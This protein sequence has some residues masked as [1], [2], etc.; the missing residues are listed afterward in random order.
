MRWD[1]LF[2]DLESEAERLSSVERDAEIEDRTRSEIGRLGL[3]DRLRPAIGNWLRVRCH[4]SVAL[5]GRLCRVAP[6]WLLLAEESGREALV[7]AAAVLSV[8]GL[9]RFSAVPD[10]VPVVEARFGLALALRG[11]SRD[12]SGV[13][14]HLVDGSVLDGTID[15]VGADFIELAIHP[16]GE[17]RRASAVRDRVLVATSGLVAVRRDG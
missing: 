2:A 9:E 11:V 15:R 7:R 14:V 4:G 8:G 3:G 13:R 12:R 17:A 16:P 10:S 5:A 6:E 1:N